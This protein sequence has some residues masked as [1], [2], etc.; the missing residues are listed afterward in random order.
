MI[1]LRSEFFSNTATFRLGDSVSKTLE[2]RWIP[3]SDFL[4]YYI[5]KSNHVSKVTKRRML[6]SSVQLSDPLKLL[7]PDA[8]TTKIILQELCNLNFLG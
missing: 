6:S 5:Q 7:L 8:I 3:R 4:Q 2:L 1:H